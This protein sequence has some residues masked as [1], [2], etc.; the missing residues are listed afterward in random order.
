MAQNE[1]IYRCIN[2]A[3]G[4]S[5]PRAV[6]FCPWCGSAQRPGAPMPQP[7][8]VGTAA[9]ATVAAPPLRPVPPA[10]PPPPP[11]PPS[12]PAA[13]SPPPAPQPAPAAAPASAA[14][15]TLGAK[16]A[17][18]AAPAK[19][20]PGRRPVRLRWWALALGVLWLVWLVAN[21]SK[22][23]IERRM[24]KAVALAKECKAREAQDE[25]IALRETR[26]TAEQLTQ[27]QRRLNDAAKACTRAEQRREAWFETR[28]AIQKLIKADAYDKARARLAVFTRRWGEDAETRALRQRIDEGRREHPLADPSGSGQ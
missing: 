2:A 6:T 28:G 1:A 17:A 24:D 18:G 11:P 22:A 14:K 9:A 7:V 16:P 19:Q 13:A 25:L 15:S 26:A 10:P 4:R 20:P 23:L 12:P 27:V 21:P 8:K 5:F 3:C